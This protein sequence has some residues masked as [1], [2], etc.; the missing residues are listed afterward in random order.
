MLLIPAIDLKDGLCVRLLRGRFE[1]ATVY[2]RDPA[3]MARRWADAGAEWI[4][5]VDL[6]GSLGFSEANLQA[7]AAVRAATDRRLQ[8]GGGLKSLDALERWFDQGLDRLILGTAV[9]EN[10]ALVEAAAGRWP[11]RVAAALDASGRRLRVWGWQ[12]DGGL[13]LLETAER[14]PDLGVSLIIHT[15]V[16]RD[17][18]QEGPNLELAAEVAEVS[19]LPTVVSG[20]ISGLEDLRAVR[21]RAA[22]QPRLTGV[23]SGRALYEGTLD[24]QAGAALLAQ[25]PDSL[26]PR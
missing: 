9:C 13:D 7:V 17:G 5:L 21:L 18:A 25:A 11:G 4:H 8:L 10:P 3:A 15:D 22:A 20:G 19:G 26:A 1:D 6:D 16:D 23:I 2:G 24:F 14:L 12:K